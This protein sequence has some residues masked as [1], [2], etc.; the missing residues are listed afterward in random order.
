MTFWCLWPQASSS[1]VFDGLTFKNKGST[2]ASLNLSLRVR[3]IQPQ[4]LGDSLAPLQLSIMM[5]TFQGYW[6]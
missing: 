5:L 6:S 3:L 4:A 1:C 2:L